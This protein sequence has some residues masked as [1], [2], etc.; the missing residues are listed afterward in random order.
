MDELF[1]TKVSQKLF[2]SD[3]MENIRNDQ[4]NVLHIN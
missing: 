3:Y 4:K 1:K 2:K